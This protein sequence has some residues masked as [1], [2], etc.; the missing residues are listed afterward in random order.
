MPAS[1]VTRLMGGSGDLSG[2]RMA[3]PCSFESFK[4]QKLS[5]GIH[6]LVSAHRIVK[7]TAREIGH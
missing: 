7:G 2:V 5:W 1:H 4:V 3:E 6:T